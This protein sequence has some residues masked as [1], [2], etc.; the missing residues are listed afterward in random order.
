[1][2]WLKEYSEAFKGSQ[3]Y[4]EQWKNARVGLKIDSSDIPWSD[5]KAFETI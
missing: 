4:I 1:M 3:E 2:L 5:F